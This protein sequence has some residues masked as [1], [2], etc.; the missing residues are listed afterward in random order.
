VSQSLTYAACLTPAGSGA[1]ATI[2]VRG[3]DA[4]LAVQKLFRTPISDQEGRFHLGKFG[5]DTADEV[6]V[7]VKQIDPVPWVEI[8]CHGGR[9]VVRMILETLE[10]HGVQ[11]CSWQEMVRSATD[12]PLRA[13]AAILLAEARTVRTAA[14]LLDQYHGAFDRK[15][16]Q[17][18]QSLERD[19][20]CGGQMLEELARYTHVGRHLTVPWRVVVAGAPNV[21]KSSLVN[22]LAGFQRSIVSAIPG[23]TRDLVRTSIA[24]DGWPIDLIDSA[25]L[26]EH[27]EGLE[28]E[29]MQ[30]TAGEMANA[31]L[32]LWVLDGA[33]N[34]SPVPSRPGSAANVLFVINKVDL[35]AGWDWSQEFEAV[36]VSAL[37]S[38]GLANLCQV[39][40]N[41]LV[42]EA[43]TAGHGVP[44]THSHCQQI[45]KARQCWHEGQIDNV[46]QIL[47]MI[48]SSS[49]SRR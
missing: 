43:P 45:E 6:V 30:L 41:R 1:I 28:K 11:I 37:T 25:G 39:M 3:L 16:G 47:Q 9:E 42:P 32:C 38:S 49:N 5:E 36:P 13:E 23:T 7:A 31:D 14:I 4:L 22:A 2:A 18:I 33:G 12:Q 19:A 20:A 29:G 8:H 46:V 27:A 10:R 35:P 15:V 21:G 40:A 26:R 17:I 34:A 24:I 48:L 44:F